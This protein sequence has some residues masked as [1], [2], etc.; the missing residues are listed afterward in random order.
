MIDFP[1]N[2][3][4]GQIFISGTRYWRWTGS[5]WDA[6]SNGIPDLWNDGYTIVRNTSGAWNSAYDTSTA[7][8][9]NSG[10]FVTKNL[11]LIYAIAL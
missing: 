7:Y 8:I 6:Y 2:P 1:D 11:S 3:Y 10:T 4:V 5:T 9:A